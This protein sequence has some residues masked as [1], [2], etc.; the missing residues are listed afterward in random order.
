MPT[1]LEQW[2]ERLERHFESLVRIRA[3]SEY[4][5]FALEHS[6]NDE[7]IEEVSSL[8]HSCLKD[9]IPL[10]RYWLPWV[11]YASEYGYIYEGEEYWRSFEKQMPQWEAEDRY[12]L[13]R[14]FKKFQEMYG[15]VVPSGRW[16]N[17]FTIISWPITH[18]ILPRYLQ[19]QF[20]KTLYDLRYR[21]A[22][23]ETLKPAVIGRLLAAQAH[24]APT[25]FQE[26]LQQEELTGRIV[27]AF[28]GVAPAGGTDPI[29]PQ[30]LQRIVGDLE[31][32]RNAREWL[33]ETRRFVRDRFTG[34]G[35]GSPRLGLPISRRGSTAPNATQFGIRPSIVLGH[36]G[37]DT[38]SVR[39]EIPSFHNVAT[40]SADIRSFLR[41]TR[42]RLNGADDIKPAGW[43]LAR[44][45][46]G[47][48][49]S[50][51]DSQKPLIQFDQS[52][53]RI[54]HLLE[55]ECRLTP[56]PIWLFRIARDGTAYEITSHIVRPRCS[57]IVVTTA[58]L[59]EPYIY[60]GM[61]ACSINCTG[62]KSFRLKIP[63]SLSEEDTAWLS[64]LDLQ[65]ARTI[66]VW[67]AGLPG[68]G[69]DGEGSSEW[70][71]TEEPCF[72][73]MHDHPVDS[74]L[75]CINNGTQ[76]VVEAGPKGE[77]IFV[78]LSSLPVGEHRLTVKAQRSS[79]LNEIVSTPA[80]EGFAQLHVREPEAWT[81]GVVSHTGFIVTLEPH[82]ADL[83][84]FWKNEVKL[85][86]LG[87]EGRS[88]AFAVSLKNRNGKEILS[89]PVANMELPVTPEAWSNR[90]SQFLE[91]EENEWSYFEAATG[92][93]KIKGEELGEF[94]CLFE[95]D[96]VPLRWVLSRDRNNIRIRLIDDTG[97]EGA[98][99]EVLFF[100]ME[101]PLKEK[102]YPSGQALSGM[103]VEPPGGLFYAE[104]G[105]HRD[106]VIVSAI[107]RNK[108]LLGLGITPDF[109]GIR[110]GSI[111]LGDCL[112]MFARWYEGRLYGTLVKVRR[113]QIADGYLDRIYETLCGQNWMRAEK[114]FL[115][116][117]N[118]QPALDALQ[119]AI[120]K[121]STGFSA[122]L[123]R[124]HEKIDE[125]LDQAEQWYS[126]LAIR[127][128]VSTD[129]KLCDFAFR[130]ATEPHL[131]SKMSGSEQDGMLNAIRDNPAILRGARFLALLHPNQNHD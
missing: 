67:P 96:S 25:R 85:S 106:V 65:V 41:G 130:L 58:E 51:P 9:R 69:W 118:S 83:D 2:Q 123:S 126:D 115:K 4:R 86:V 39:L 18:A 124:E 74:Y 22:G 117:P 75:L 10:A 88:V 99:P 73:F 8:L 111:A 120:E 57:Y 23:L 113:E 24:H 66:Q 43:L 35:S 64:K 1:H 94:S 14:C 72:G 20:A 89:K 61:S 122:T 129:P 101:S 3:D 125:N 102:Q 48:L 52:H 30:T 90:F 81:P 107:P 36:R 128:H 87:P 26:F 46:K 53:G 11:I 28:L 112:R 103:I 62:V 32:V 95:H 93:I 131:L 37:G 114:D 31:R 92:Q 100:G 116:A 13:R 5:I 121:K 29:Y 44:N 33:G 127:Y 98:A 63:S 16:A 38:W 50:W 21:L 40:L 84:I 105:D 108:G 15:G 7:E 76:T 79:S 34:I 91:K 78:R 119:Q 71:T 47:V 56:G 70:L 59:P 19:R 54:D 82:D 104:Q 42:C 55:S 49:R 12:K 45:R 27:L 60:N 110:T 17:H 68:R 6:L 97:Q 80:A 77:P 109:F